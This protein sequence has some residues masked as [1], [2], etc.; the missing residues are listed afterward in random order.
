[1]LNYNVRTR[2]NTFHIHQRAAP[3]S[4]SSNSRLYIYT[5]FHR[6]S[7]YGPRYIRHTAREEK[8]AATRKDCAGSVPPPPLS[9]RY[10]CNSCLEALFSI[11]F[12]HMTN[13]I[14]SSQR[15]KER[16]Q[17]QER[18]SRQI[19]WERQKREVKGGK[20]INSSDRKASSC[21]RILAIA[22]N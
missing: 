15:G 22:L 16:R 19:T 6:F 12:V 7:T 8:D 10:S 4:Q 1:M 20:G 3:Y 9:L 17:C 21:S 5:S 2:Q 11:D 13:I 14:F 18:T